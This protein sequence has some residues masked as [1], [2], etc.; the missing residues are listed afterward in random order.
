M[1]R[2]ARTIVAAQLALIIGVAL[3]SGAAAQESR[4]KRVSTVAAPSGIHKIKHVFVIMQENRSFDSYFGTFP[5]ADGIPKGV[6]LHDPRNGGCRRPFAD[7]FDSNRN[8]PHSEFPFKADVNGGKMN[9][10]VAEAEKKL[11]KLGHPCHPRVMGYH[12][13]TDIRNYWA[14]AKN[15]VLQD[16]MFES[17]GSWSLPAHLY[18]VSAWS[19]R[20]SRGGVAMSCTSSNFPQ[21]RSASRPVPFAWTD[22]TWLLHRHH[23]S[24]SF[25]LDHGAV[26][27]RNPGG[28]S[29]T[30]N[31]LPGFTDVHKDRQLGNIRPLR[32]FWK[33]AKAGRLPKVSWFSP[34]FRD[35]EHGPALVSTGQAYVTRIIN[36]IMRS[37]AWRSSA[38]F[39]A[40]DDWGGF[41]DHVPPPYVDRLGYG[42]RVPAMVISPYAKRGF[43]DHQ[44]L[45]YDAYLKFI[46]D[47]FMAGARLNPRTDGRRDRRP[48]VR[49]SAAK[50]G[51]LAK[52]FNFSQT[53][54]RRFILNPCPLS[55]LKPRPGPRC[56]DHINLHVSTWGDT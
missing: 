21:E 32:V 43:I 19:A 34:D 52:D 51:N 7:H 55:T 16:H 24:W 53:P 25:Y 18:E 45:S 11:C 47:D 26:S 20:C 10:F 36:A 46:E 2:P 30:W 23:V 48:D 40:W 42:I 37:P 5:G 1:M 4:P 12:V 38:I 27:S 44:R 31:P 6:C 39:L 50:L 17:A 15:F 9:G 28:V 29:V 22:L 56:I 54:R 3:A 13:R 41:Y 33:Q 14:Y 8:Y 49:E 35:S